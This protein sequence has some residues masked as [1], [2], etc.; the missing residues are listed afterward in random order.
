MIVGQIA[1]LATIGNKIDDLGA[2][3]SY[4]R[5]GRRRLPFV[6]RELPFGKDRRAIKRC[7]SSRA[8]YARRADFAQAPIYVASLFI[9]LSDVIFWLFFKRNY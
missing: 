9:I 5:R 2:S 4:S 1:S 3:S 7:A 8:Q 6:R